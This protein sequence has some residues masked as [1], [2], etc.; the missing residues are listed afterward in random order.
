M[1]KTN[2]INIGQLYVRNTRYNSSP[3][4]NLKQSVYSVMQSAVNL[5]TVSIKDRKA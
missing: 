5:I 3:Y 4:W 2:D 1:G